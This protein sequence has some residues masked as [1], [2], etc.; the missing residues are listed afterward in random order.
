[1]SRFTRLPSSA[2][3]LTGPDR[4]DFV[5]GQM[6]AHIK[7]APTPGMVPAC[8]LNVRGQIEQFARV[9]RRADD[10]Y[11]HLDDLSGTG[12]QA[13][14]LAARLKKYIIFDQVEVHDV[15][16]VLA[17]LHLW[18]DALAT[19]LGWDAAGPDVQSFEFG[20]GVVL[21]GRVNRSGESGLDVH[22]LRQHE[23][24]LLAALAAS[25][26]PAVELEA[27]RIAAG[28]SDVV[29]DGWQGSLPQEVGQDAAVS[30]RKGCYVG[31]EIMARL[32]ARGNTRHAL[33]LLS[34]E[35][36]PAHSE[37]RHGD[38]V[39]GQTGASTGRLALA[40]L[41]KDLPEDAGLRVGE[42]EARVVRAPDPSPV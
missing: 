10:V 12:E 33:T 29:R 21:A 1:M 18:P 41:R 13:A 19:L 22:Y 38:R 7:A 5:Q 25:E 14:V 11:L 20:G 8:F 35:G 34:G 42:V 16:P 17:S 9:Y 30:Y 23:A 32:E 36:L 27:A 24:T 2:L 40:K 26:V 31:Q 28:L 4:L 39:V 3:R 37:V 6:T 15:T